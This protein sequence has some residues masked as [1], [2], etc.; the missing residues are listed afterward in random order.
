[1][2][3]MRNKFCKFSLFL[4]L[5]FSALHLSAQKYNDA[6]K[7]LLDSFLPGYEL[8]QVDSIGHSFFVIQVAPTFRGGLKG[9]TAY[10]EKNLDRD[11]GAKYIKVK[12]GDSVVK[13]SVVVSFIVQPS[14]LIS[15]VSAEPPPKGMDNHPKIVAEAIR[16]VAEGPR[17]EPAQQE[18]FEIVNGK[19]PIQE[20]LERKKRGFKKLL[21]RHKQSITFV[22]TVEK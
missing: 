8:R 19:L 16:V 15:D 22:V 14:G 13:Q 12:K 2:M 3:L 11:L 21:Y 20:I 17:W 9:W 4:F 6:E 18:T 7:K 1:M 10:L 5:G